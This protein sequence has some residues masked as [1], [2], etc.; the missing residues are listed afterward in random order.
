MMHG[1][2]DEV[3]NMI[4][5]AAFE[6]ISFV[7]GAAGVGESAERAAT[8]LKDILFDAMVPY[9]VVVKEDSPIL[10]GT[11]SINKVVSEIVEMFSKTYQAHGYMEIRGSRL[12]SLI[13]TFRLTLERTFMQVPRTKEAMKDKHPELYPPK[14]K[15]RKGKV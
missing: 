13:T 7:W 3:A 6:A 12:K 8:E 14:T 4:R 1:N 11:L 10:Y 2:K 5:E 15:R 9:L